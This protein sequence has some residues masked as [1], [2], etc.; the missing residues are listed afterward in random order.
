MV[1]IKCEVRI[2][3][4]ESP[5]KVYI[6]TNGP[7]I[8]RILGLDF[9]FVIATPFKHNQITRILLL[10]DKWQKITKWHGTVLNSK[11]YVSGG[12]LFIVANPR[13]ECQNLYMQLSPQRSRQY[14]LYKIHSTMRFILIASIILFIGIVKVH[15]APQP[16]LSL[17][18][19]YFF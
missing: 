11:N 4:Y 3:I 6:S 17:N 18:K 9:F 19:R 8:M 5:N 15:S 2:V 12:P 14:Q 13:Q 16:D 7:R 1:H 10:R